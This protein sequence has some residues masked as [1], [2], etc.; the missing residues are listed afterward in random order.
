[1]VSTVVSAVDLYGSFS[2]LNFVVPCIPWP[3]H[4][5]LNVN[6]NRDLKIMLI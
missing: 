5:N 6:F 3:V 1:M 2:F 4:K